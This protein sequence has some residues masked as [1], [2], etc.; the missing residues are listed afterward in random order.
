MSA[1]RNPAFVKVL[2]LFHSAYFGV[3]KSAQH[4]LEKAVI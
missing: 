1:Q 2:Y 3:V 4:D